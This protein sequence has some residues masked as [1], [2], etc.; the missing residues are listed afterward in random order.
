MWLRTPLPTAR[1]APIRGPCPTA[2]CSKFSLGT[3][4]SHWPGGGAPAPS[5]H[6]LTHPPFLRVS[7]VHS[8]HPKGTTQSPGREHA[9][10]REAHLVHLPPPWAP[11]PCHHSPFSFQPEST[12]DSKYNSLSKYG[13]YKMTFK[14]NT[15]LR[16]KIYTDI[17]L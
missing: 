9:Q 10:E 17:K 12:W 4:D 15:V 2:G 8:R 3:S 1:N 6:L 7:L 5:P 14:K 11:F 16:Q 13:L